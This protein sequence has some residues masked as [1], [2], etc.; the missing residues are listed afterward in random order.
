MN[1]NVRVGVQVE[2]YQKLYYAIRNFLKCTNSYLLVVDSHIKTPIFNKILNLKTCHSTLRSNH[3]AYHFH[4]CHTVFYVVIWWHSKVF[5]LTLSI[6]V[7]IP[8]HACFH[9]TR[10][11]QCM[12]IEAVFIWESVLR[13]LSSKVGIQPIRGAAEVMWRHHALLVSK[14][15]MAFVVITDLPWIK[16]T[17]GLCRL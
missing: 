17:M 5:K 6:V 13:N 16:F 9:G 7:L 3:I 15:K 12:V 11:I 10:P 8:T 2:L 14:A 4:K 1:K